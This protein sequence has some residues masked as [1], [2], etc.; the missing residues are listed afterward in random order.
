MCGKWFQSS[1]L[2]VFNFSG[3]GW[4]EVV[5]KIGVGSQTIY[6]ILYIE[7]WLSSTLYKI[8]YTYQYFANG[9]TT[10][11]MRD[12]M[13]FG[14]IQW[15][16]LPNRCPKGGC[17]SPD[18]TACNSFPGATRFHPGAAL[19]RFFGFTQRLVNHGTPASSGSITWWSMAISGT[20]LLEVPTIYKAYVRPYI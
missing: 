6:V 16:P 14:K 1:F 15:M 17:C 13:F 5:H 8:K 20:D 3:L 11:G 7:Y 19:V 18:R 4:R 12:P 2:S 10:A 9:K